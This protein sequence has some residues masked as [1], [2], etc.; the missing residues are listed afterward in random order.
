M[1]SK[2]YH[3]LD[4]DGCPVVLIELSNRPGY[5]A[6]LD[7]DDFHKWITAHRSTNFFAVTRGR[8]RIYVGHT[9]EGRG[10]LVARTLLR[11]GPGFVIQ[12]ADKDRLNLRRNN[13]RLV[14]L[15][16]ATRSNSN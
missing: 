8:H 11:P 13:L 1:K 2:E 9:L 15:A 6:K 12:H 14:K 4:D 3:T 16:T 5:S 7:L 10:A